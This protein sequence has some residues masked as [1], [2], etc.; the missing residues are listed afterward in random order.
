MLEEATK[1]VKLETSSSWQH[2]SPYKEELELLRVSGDVR[3]DDTLMRQAIKGGTAGGRSE[4][5]KGDRLNAW[6]SAKLRECYSEVEQEDEE[7][8]STVQQILQK[9]TDFPE[10]DHRSSRMAARVHTLSYVC[11]HWHR[12]PLEDRMW[13]VS[14]KHGTVLLEEPGQIHDQTG[15]HGP[16]RGEGVLGSCSA[17]GLVR[18]SYECTQSSWRTSKREVTV[19]VEVLVESPRTKQVK[20]NGSAEKGHHGGQPCGGEDLR[21]GEEPRNRSRWWSPSFAR[22]CRKRRFVR[23]RMG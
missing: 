2:E 23:E 7:R 4:L 16:Q 21:L 12:C 3:L 11:L 1:A 5:V 9:S 8:K 6:T 19:P 14:T 20:G 15:Q 22:T 10:A 18:E 17:A 13:W